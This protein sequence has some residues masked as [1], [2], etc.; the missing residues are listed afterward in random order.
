MVEGRSRMTV[1]MTAGE[2]KRSLE[3]VDDRMRVMM[4]V[5]EPALRQYLSER[6]WR[7]MPRWAQWFMRRFETSFVRGCWVEAHWGGTS[8][9]EGNPMWRQFVI[10]S[11]NPLI[12]FDSMEHRD[13]PPERQLPVGQ[14]IVKR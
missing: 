12:G 10:H 5:E 1:G 4:L 6:Y 14:G 8:A 13:F 3:G 7:Q 11:Y 9:L 2:L